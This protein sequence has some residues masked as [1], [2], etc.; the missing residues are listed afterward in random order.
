MGGRGSSSL[1]ASDKRYYENQRAGFRKIAEQAEKASKTEMNRYVAET[2]RAAE[3]LVGT[4][5]ARELLND[6]VF[7]GM[8]A[9]INMTQ[10]PILS[11]Q[12]AMR[13]L[14]NLLDNDTTNRPLGSAMTHN[15]W[16]AVKNAVQ[17]DY[18]DLEARGY[19]KAEIAAALGDGHYLIREGEKRQGSNSRMVTT[20]RNGKPEQV[21]RYYKPKGSNSRIKNTYTTEKFVPYT[22]IVI[23]A[24]VM[25]YRYGGPSQ[26]VYKIADIHSGQF[27]AWLEGANNRNGFAVNVFRDNKGWY[28]SS[29]RLTGVNGEE[30]RV[31]L[32]DLRKRVGF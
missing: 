10:E 30:G 24:A 11:G 4:D 1:S 19:T 12:S 23:P 25:S 28:L 20:Y 2:A 29:D 5:R 32:E 26:E 27:G 9:D 22:G 17:R 13:L 31:Y 8:K 7:K 18:A 3:S 14:E 16:Q 6:G 21:P 15:E